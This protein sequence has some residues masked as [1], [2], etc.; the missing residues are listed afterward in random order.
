[1][2]LFRTHICWTSYTTRNVI[3]KETVVFD[4]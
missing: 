4:S 3:S 1:M 2:K